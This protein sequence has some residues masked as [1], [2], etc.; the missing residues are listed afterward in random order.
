MLLGSGPDF[1]CHTVVGSC[2][3]STFD[4][5][6]CIIG[7]NWI[8]SAHSA[9]PR[10]SRARTNTRRFRPRLLRACSVYQPPVRR[11]QRRVC[12]PSRSFGR[13]SIR[14]LRDSISAQVKDHSACWTGA[15]QRAK[16]PNV[17]E[18]WRGPLG[19]CCSTSVSAW[20][21]IRKEPVWPTG[22]WL[23][24]TL[25]RTADNQQ[26]ERETPDDCSASTQDAR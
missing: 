24:S 19:L 22:S 9:P 13:R 23:L 20:P 11:R 16:Q 7:N 10:L 15:C 26:R 18:R 1:I 8:P 12:L 14:A 25:G 4:V 5:A 17:W 6:F 21:S 2:T 3:S